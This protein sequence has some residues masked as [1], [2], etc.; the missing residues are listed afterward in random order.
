MKNNRHY[1][2]IIAGTTLGLLIILGALI[3]RVQD[4]RIEALKDE[5]YLKKQNEQRASDYYESSLNIKTIQS[6]FNTLQEYAIQKGNKINMNHKY[7][8]TSDGILGLKHEIVLTGNGK[9]QYDVNVKF[10]TAVVS[11]TDG[12]NIKVQIEKPYVDED[13]IKLVENSLVMK[14]ADCNI[15]SNKQD[16]MQAQKFFTDSF[17]ES[18]R[19]NIKDLYKTRDKQNYI[20]KVAIAEVQ[21]LIRTFNLHNCNIVVEIIE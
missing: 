5:L 20:N 4:G 8:Y 17:V 14:S 11:S 18:G 15:W 21:A 1:I 9:L 12:K 7:M 2:N 3:F 13:S 10:N 6:E 19:E 16:G